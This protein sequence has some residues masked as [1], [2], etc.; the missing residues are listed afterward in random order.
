MRLGLS[1]LGLTVI[2]ITVGV[3]LAAGLRGASASHDIQT[4]F[5]GYS[6]DNSGCTTIK[7]PIGV[8]FTQGSGSLAQVYD[9]AKLSNHGGWATRAGGQ[10]FYDTGAA[11]GGGCTSY[12]DSAASNDGNSGCGDRW[13]F[14]YEVAWN[15]EGGHSYASTPHFDKGNGTWPFTCHHCV[16]QDGFTQGKTAVMQHWSWD[17]GL[18][19]TS[20]SKYWGNTAQAQQSCGYA[21]GGTGWVWY[22]SMTGHP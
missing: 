4:T 21:S 22:L 9:H 6:Y 12:D 10:Y 14:R 8:V 11:P 17:T 5:W 16:P 7:D 3:A 20:E 19:P 2:S 15:P 1:R 18:H 13:H